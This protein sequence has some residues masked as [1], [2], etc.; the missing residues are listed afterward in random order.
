A[1]H[2]IKRLIFTSTAYTWPVNPYGLSKIQ[3]EKDI[4]KFAKEHNIKVAI[5][6]PSIVMG[7]KNGYCGMPFVCKGS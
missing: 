2:N 5:L 7:N 1:E 6:K 3:N 4:A